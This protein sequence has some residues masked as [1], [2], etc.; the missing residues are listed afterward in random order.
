MR[1]YELKELICSAGSRVSSDVRN[2]KI[3]NLLSHVPASLQPVKH[4]T[5]NDGSDLWAYMSLHAYV[6]VFVR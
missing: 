1:L 2:E 6:Q 3:C 4:L 5:P